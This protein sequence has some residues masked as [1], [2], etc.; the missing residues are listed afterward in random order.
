MHIVSLQTGNDILISVAA[1]IWF[2][3]MVA[4]SAKSGAVMSSPWTVRRLS[5]SKHNF[6]H[7]YSR[8]QLFI[9]LV[10]ATAVL[11]FVLCYVLVGANL[12]LLIEFTVAI[13]I[14][15]GLTYWYYTVAKV[16][17]D[18]PKQ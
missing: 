10:I 12:Q 9:R 4:L 14:P 3:A 8:L 17:D 15:C 13:T 18:K 16:E 11:S 2:A 1:G 7:D 5:R 6:G